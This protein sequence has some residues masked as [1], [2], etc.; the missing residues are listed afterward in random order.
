MS[1][2]YYGNVIIQTYSVYI[3]KNGDLVI[4][5]DAMNRKIYQHQKLGILGAQHDAYPIIRGVILFLKTKRCSERIGEAK[6]SEDDG[7]KM[8]LATIVYK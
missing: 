8:N 3:I 4:N 1:Y 7:D 2:I 6:E 5:L